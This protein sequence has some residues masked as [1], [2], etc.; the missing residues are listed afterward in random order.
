MYQY[1]TLLFCDLPPRK[2]EFFSDLAV[3]QGSTR[4]LLT[5]NSQWPEKRAAQETRKWPQLAKVHRQSPTQ[6]KPSHTKDF[7][8]VICSYTRKGMF[9][10]HCLCN[11][12]NN[13]EANYRLLNLENRLRVNGKDHFCAASAQ[14][15]R[16]TNPPRTKR[17]NACVLPISPR[18]S[19]QLTL[20]MPKYV[21]TPLQQRERERDS[22]R[23]RERD[24]Y[25]YIYIHI[26]M[27]W[28]YYLVQVWGF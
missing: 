10:R 14:I 5:Q 19:C 26:Y 18:A 9:L 15:R 7:F 17:E 28:S 16:F 4:K 21:P 20:E 24:K 6:K 12:P 2:H 8:S 25:K 3:A 23:E 27:L 1:S 13:W 22:E 11:S